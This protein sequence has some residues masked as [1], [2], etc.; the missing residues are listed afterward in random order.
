MKPQ[1]DKWL[2]INELAAYL[3]LSRSK[4]YDMAQQG[5]IPASKIGAQWRF[6]RDEIDT[7]MKSKKE[8]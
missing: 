6:D 8:V 5:A 3:K 1:I 2:T 7:W 4:L